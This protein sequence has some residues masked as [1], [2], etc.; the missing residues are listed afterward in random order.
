MQ[1]LFAM[2][3][4]IHLVTI[5]YMDTYCMSGFKLVAGD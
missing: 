5:K 4:S 2:P 3:V 1:L